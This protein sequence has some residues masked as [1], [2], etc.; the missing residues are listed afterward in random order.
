MDVWNKLNF[1]KQ[2]NKQT[3][4]VD[5]AAIDD[6]HCLNFLFIPPP[7]P[8]NEKKK[9]KKAKQYKIKTIQKKTKQ[10]KTNKQTKQNKTKINKSHKSDKKKSSCNFTNT[11]VNLSTVIF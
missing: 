11:C 5:I 1:N 7:P 8:P 9:K 2:T 6:H 4:F 10:N 3:K